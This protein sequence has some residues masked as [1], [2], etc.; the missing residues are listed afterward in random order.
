MYRTLLM[1]VSFA[2]YV[3]GCSCETSNGCESLEDCR[4]GSICVEGRC[5]LDPSIDGSLPDGGNGRIDG[6]AE[7]LTIEPLDPTIETDGSA[8]T[9]QFR[10]RLNG[11][12]LSSVTWVVDDVVV[13]T[14][15]P[16]GLL[17][18]RGMVAG[19]VEVTA[20]Y[21]ALRA[22]SMVTVRVN[23]MTNAVDGLS[24][25][26]MTSLRAG[27]VS[28]SSFRW[29]YPYD[30]T[31]FPRGLMAPVL[32]L[33]GDAEVL[34]VNIDVDAT[35]FHYEGFFPGS[36]PLRV[37]LPQSVWDGATRS[38]GASD[39]VVVGVTKLALGVAA[40]PITE[41]FRIAQGEL[42]GSI[43]YN[44]YDSRLAGGAALLRVRIGETAE[45]VESG[46]TVCHSVSANGN[47]IATARRWSETGTAT[48]T[49][50]PVESG[51]IDLDSRGGA[52]AAWTDPDGRKFS[53]GAL[54]PDGAA[55][56][57]NAVPPGNSI[58]GLTGTM[59]SRLWSAT[60][61]AEIAAPS[62]TDAALYAVT[63]QFAPDGSRL[64]F[65]WFRD[66]NE[67]NERVLAVM[68]ADLA[69]SPPAFGPPVTV[70]E[71]S[72]PGRIVGWPSFIPAGDGIVYQEGDDF[73]T[74]LMGP[75]TGGPNRSTYADIRL[76]DLTACNLDGSHCSVSSL[77]RLNGYHDGAFALPYGEDEEAH[78]N[79]EPTVLPI[80]IGGYYW[81]V[82]TSRRCY[83]NTIAPGG[84]VAGGDDR[85][86]HRSASGAEIP[87]AR[88]KL[89]VAAIDL[90]GAPGADRSHPAFYLPGQELE[91]GNMRGFVALDP[92]R[93]DGESCDSA[94]ECC[95]GF[96]RQTGAGEDGNPVFQCLPRPDGCSEE[97][98]ACE[99]AADCCGV[100]Q[101]AQCINR[102]CAHSVLF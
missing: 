3:L 19:Q 82:F 58:R 42:T 30:E 31:V 52:M 76:V 86:G 83:G 60:T 69:S 94:A 32:Q 72:T 13:G 7:G 16:V 61:G 35:G 22:K 26:A 18:A 100:A 75:E 23:A 67:L 4:A 48:G 97:L 91:S 29:L 81:V 12:E 28:D 39:S 51:T 70:V 34:R 9:I 49:G 2:L 101:G 89:W 55:V 57:S 64:A 59:A 8:E 102:R 43:Y 74:A 41:R 54:T 62:L 20:V 27:G 80:A 44:S 73:D 90:S 50:N 79:Y 14:I 1:L 85:W 77:E 71:L 21:G 24:P 6:S 40:G 63:P 36:S 66:G 37:T 47:R 95:G 98:E 56:L 78:S 92:C 17:T 15:S 25:E 87:S 5:V 88:K 10:A 99:T 11:I 38:A 68:S 53:F 93:A 45:V 65:S 84:T 46:C 33:S 96:C